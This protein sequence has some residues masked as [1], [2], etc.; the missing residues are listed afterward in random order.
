[1]KDQKGNVVPCQFC[2]ELRYK[3][4][5]GVYELL[6]VNE[7]ARKVIMGG[8]SINQLKTVF[9]KQRGYYLQEVALAQVEAGETSVQEVLR[10]LRGE[11]QAA[12]APPTAP[13]A[14]AAPTKAERA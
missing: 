4:R 6:L 12:A 8:G 9:R 14:A 11:Q 7:D 1:M 3:G 5:F 10:V 13:V 2:Q